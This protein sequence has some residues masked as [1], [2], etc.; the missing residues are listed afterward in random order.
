M[1]GEPEA[2]PTEH[3]QW[4]TYRAQRTNHDA[5][6]VEWRDR[7]AAI[8]REIDWLYS[9]PFERDI[10]KPLRTTR[11]QLDRVDTHRGELTGHRFCADSAIERIER[12]R[13]GCDAS[14]GGVRAA[15]TRLH[16]AAGRPGRASARAS[17][18]PRERQ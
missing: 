18:H 9:Q 5:R 17:G 6:L 14:R 1:V 12:T 2:A 4:I 13:A 7:R 10:A 3:Q 11:R 16:T 15:P 8:Q